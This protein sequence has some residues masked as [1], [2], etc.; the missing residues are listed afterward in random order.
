MKEDC[1]YGKKKF[2][3]K[4]FQDMDPGEIQEQTDTIPWEL[5]EDLMEV[6][7]SDP[8]PKKEEDTEEQVSEKLIDIIQS[9]I[10]VPII[11]DS[12]G[13]LVQN[14]PSM[15]QALKL[16]QTMEE[17]LVPYRN[18][19]RE[20]KKQKADITM[21]FYKVTVCLPL[22][23]LLPSPPPL[24]PLPPLR[25][26]DQALPFFF[27]LLLHLFNMKTTRL[28]TFMMMIHFHVMNSK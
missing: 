6:S 16:K 21:C 15:I 1:G 2:G 12:F 22:L 11:Q 28:K 26:E 13:L 23:H 8:V 9:D 14:G 17:G 7:T 5:T 24:W 10:R 19:F 25:N 27:F 20:M 18:I 4:G 3:G